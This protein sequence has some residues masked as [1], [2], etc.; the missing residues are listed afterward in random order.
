MTLTPIELSLHGISILVVTKG[1]A[2]SMVSGMKVIVAPTI[3]TDSKM[4]SAFARASAIDAPGTITC[5]EA[6]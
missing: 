6:A 4:A 1:V 5:R 2:S 3:P